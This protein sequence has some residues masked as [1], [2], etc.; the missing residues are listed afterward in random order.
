MHTVNRRGFLGQ[1]LAASAGMAGCSR[2]P[3]IS[4][5]FSDSRVGAPER[6]NPIAVATYSFWRF[7]ENTKVS[8]EQC[9]DQAGEMGFSAVDVLHIQMDSEENSYLQHLKR[10]AALNGL[11]LCC[12]ST[13]QGFVTPDPQRRQEQVDRTIGQIELA[14]KLGIPLMR[15]NTG[16]WGMTKSFDELMANRG[17]EPPLPGYSNEDAFP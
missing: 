9:I 16:R 17:I 6:N 2:S 5:A 11:D 14:Y 12:L 4:L 8:I 3:S 13:H 7:R 1:T 15:V 10:R